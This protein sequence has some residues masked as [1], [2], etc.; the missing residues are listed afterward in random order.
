MMDIR[1][2]LLL[3]HSKPNAMKIVTFIGNDKRRFSQLM[4]LFFT[5]EYRVVQ[6]AAQVVSICVES[7]PSLIQPYFSEI[8]SYIHQPCHVAVQRNILRILRFID[9]PPEY[10][11]QIIEICFNFILDPKA[12]IAVRAF[13][14]HIIHKLSMSYPEILSELKMVL[15]NLPPE[16][17]P[18]IKSCIRK[19]LK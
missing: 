14:I 2:Q 8:V 10:H 15:K 5:D 7:H 9:I 19:V 11:G 12:A 18:A 16:E 1:S 3:E 6:R 17:P 13:S 4:Q